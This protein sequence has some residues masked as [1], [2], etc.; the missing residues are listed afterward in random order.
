[1]DLPPTAEERLFEAA[2]IPI[3]PIVERIRPAVPRPRDLFFK[4]TT[5]KSNAAGTR[6]TVAKKG[7]SNAI[8]PSTTAAIPEKEAVEVLSFTPDFA[9]SP[10][11]NISAPHFGHTLS[12]SGVKISQEPHVFISELP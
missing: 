4:A 9:F 8:P 5:E 1:V 12:E 11:A 6:N 7:R 2:S 10:T 3:T